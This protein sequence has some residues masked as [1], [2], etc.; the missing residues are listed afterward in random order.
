MTV[1]TLNDLTKEYDG[2]QL[3]APINLSIYSDERVAVIGKNGCGK[4]TL[5]K[6]IINEVIPDKG[7]VI[8]P[9]N[10]TIGYLSQSVISDLNLT[11]YKEV[12]STFSDVIK[13]QKRIEELGTLISLD[14]NNASYLKEY[15]SLNEYILKHD[16]YNYE[17]KIYSML[18]YFGFKEEDFEREVESFSGGERMK[19]AF[20]KLLLSNPDILILDEPTNHLDISTIKW[21][22]D[23]LKTYKGT[24]LFVSHDK[25]FINSLATK[26]LEI[27]DKKVTLYTGDYD[28]YSAQKKIRYET[29]LKQFLKQ[30]KERKK[31]EWFIRFYMPKPR[32]VSRAHDRE[33][34][35]ERLNKTG[36]KKPHQEKN[37][38]HMRFN[39][40]L[41]EGKRI[42]ECKNLRIGYDKPLVN[43]IDFTFFGGDHYAILGDNGTGKTTFIKT[44]LNQI[45]PYSGKVNFYDTFNIGYLK[46]DGL[47]IDSDEKMFDYFSNLFPSMSTQD[48]YNTLGTFSFDYD[49]FYRT[50]ST[51]SG[52]EKMRLVLATLTAKNYELLILD[53]PTNHLDMFSKEELVDALKKYKGSLII[54]SH[55]RSFI[56]ETI[57]HL[58]YFYN[59]KA[60]VYNG[61][62]SEFEK[63]ELD[64]IIQEFEEKLE[65]YKVKQVK[66][67]PIVKAKEVKRRRPELSY[68]KILQKI[69][70]V[71]KLLLDLKS[72]LDK[73]E[74]YL[75]YNKLN[76]LNNDIEKNEKLLDSLIYDLSYYE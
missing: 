49:D 57:N 15:D 63:E 75:D 36:I 62:Y 10:I 41:R 61:N 29:E 65:K 17:Y 8:I 70:K 42:F 45:P 26:V 52:G 11:L 24:I 71:E 66:E 34:K 2:E 4:S 69:D 56:D 5:I 33:K 64:G 44:I 38:V 14:H 59:E 47:L 50:V 12:E 7:S 20:C 55:D 13:T 27:E 67:K 16:G 54:I 46:Q 68:D 53:E 48:I 60:H 37:T 18:S 74:F 31:L 25:Y 23:H 30:E 72:N 76:E 51:L 73:E 35:L 6:M 3:F 43:E 1:I 21:L 9:N 58:I 28:K 32:F 22:E 39:G 40:T 19:I